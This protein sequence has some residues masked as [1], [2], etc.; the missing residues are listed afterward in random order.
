RPSIES[1][2]ATLQSVT[3]FDGTAISPDGKLVAW[4]RKV[5]DASG[6]LKLA[7]VEVSTVAAPAKK[8]RRVTAASDGRDHDEKWPAWSPDGKRF[9]AEAAEGSGTNNYWIAQ[10]YVVDAGTG[11]ARSIWKPAD[12]IACPRFSPDGKEVAVIHGLMSDEGS[13]GGD[14][15][16]VPASGGAPKNRTEG[17]KASASALFWRPSGEILFTEHVDG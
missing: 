6:A 13:T 12:Q 5:K 15:W 11:S 2:L 7:A 3:E 17:M 16:T 14:I 4:A 8:P 1:V 9:A 10:L